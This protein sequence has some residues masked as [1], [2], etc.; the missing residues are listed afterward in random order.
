ML[1]QF[2]RY[3]RFNSPRNLSTLLISNEGGCDYKYPGIGNI[4]YVKDLITE[5]S[6]QETLIVHDSVVQAHLD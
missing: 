5:R 2:Y 3:Y 6:K 1:S 4:E